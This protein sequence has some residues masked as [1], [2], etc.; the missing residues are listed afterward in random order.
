MKPPIERFVMWLPGEPDPLDLS[1]R[2][3][4]RRAG[5]AAFYVTAV[6]VTGA[7]VLVPWPGAEAARLIGGGPGALV[8]AALV[9]MIILA[10]PG[11]HRGRAITGAL[12]IAATFLSLLPGPRGATPS[13]TLL[14]GLRA[15]TARLLPAL[16]D[17]PSAEDGS[18]T[19]AEV[20]IGSAP[21]V[22]RIDPDAAADGGEPRRSHAC[23]A[24]AGC[25]R[26]AGHPTAHRRSPRPGE[27]RCAT[28]HEPQRPFRPR[29]R[30]PR[31]ARGR[32]RAGR[33]LT[34]TPRLGG[35]RR[36]RALPGAADCRAL[37]RR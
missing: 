16:A 25:R 20:W 23:R 33:V 19:D 36:N 12:A 21:A 15:T 34:L 11:R 17:R 14:A 10:L 30:C 1:R 22:V 6:L 28:A 29:P 8:L 2:R 9:G 18:T 13:A 27:C 31:P 35:H 24:R 32:R 7:A 26:P 37:P 3:P 4:R 5:G